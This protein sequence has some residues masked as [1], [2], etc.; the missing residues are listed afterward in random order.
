MR[1]CLFILDLDDNDD[2][3]DGGGHGG[4]SRHPFY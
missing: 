3:D 4:S 1:P 2:G